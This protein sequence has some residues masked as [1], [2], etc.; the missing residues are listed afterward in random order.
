[1]MLSSVLFPQPDGPSR[2]DE[3]AALDFERDVVERQRSGA[4]FAPAK[5][6][7][8]RSTMIA[9]ES[10]GEPTFTGAQQDLHRR[11]VKNRRPQ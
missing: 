2:R 6:C 3:L 10:M 8:T 4:P 5:R 1:M 11:V 7:E 9:A